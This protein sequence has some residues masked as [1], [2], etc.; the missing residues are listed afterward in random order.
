MKPTR[1][2]LLLRQR[3]GWASLLDWQA[4]LENPW[5]VRISAI[6]DFSVFYYR[7]ILDA[8][9]LAHS[10]CERLKSQNSSCSD[11][12]ALKQSLFGDQSRKP[13]DNLP[14]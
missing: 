8:K 1:D 5:V 11:N 3:S 4:H 6:V 7:A 9:Y 2:N 13:N 12:R 14:S 10:T